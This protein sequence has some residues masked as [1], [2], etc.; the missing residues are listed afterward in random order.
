MTNKL[1]IKELH[2]TVDGKE[3][4]KGVNLDVNLNEVTVL[5]GPNGSGK[6]TFANV[7]L[8][9]PK[10]KVER[11][12]IHFNG[13]DITNMKPSE[14]AKLGLFLSFQYPAEISGVTIANF[15]RTALN[16]RRD[17]KIS[18]AEF[19]DI[20]NEKL[21]TLNLDDKFVNR[22]LNE[23]F[24][25]GEK[26][27]CEMLQLAVLDEIDSGLDIPSL[28]LIGES[29]DRMNKTQKM[30][31]LIITHYERILKYLKPDRVHV[32]IDGKIVKSG[33]HE[34]VDMIEKQGYDWLKTGKDLIGIS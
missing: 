23:G 30:G 6:S 13:T 32:M 28:Q 11:G 31:I 12:S 8:G 26:K 18:V 5:M 25:G 14:R 24:S 20:L 10:F 29:I 27:K 1:E 22:Y 4:V 19:K 15:L 21:K 16:A 7:L 34:L 3:I 9:N 2:V 17:N 33:N